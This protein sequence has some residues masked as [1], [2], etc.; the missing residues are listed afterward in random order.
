MGKINTLGFND[1]RQ[2]FIALE[3]GLEGFCNPYLATKTMNSVRTIRGLGTSYVYQINKL[4]NSG[5]TQTS[6]QTI[7]FN[8]VEHL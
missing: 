6:V 2:G 3:Q 7:L 4:I 1:F 5:C 8:K